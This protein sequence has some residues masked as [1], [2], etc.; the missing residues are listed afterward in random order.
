MLKNPRANYFIWGD[1][2]AGKTHL[3]AAQYDH[4]LNED[5]LLGNPGVAWASELELAKDLRTQF[6]GDEDYIPR[7]DL[8]ELAGRPKLHFFLDDLGKAKATE[9]LRQEL[10]FLV[11]MLFRNGFG[12]SVT[13]NEP[14]EALADDDRIGGAVVRRID[15]MCELLHI[16]Y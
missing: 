10:L 12:L 2:S 14:L 3:L 8:L 13:A 1:Y 7:I 11:D 16:K 6:S 5:Y 4:V 15:D 9:F